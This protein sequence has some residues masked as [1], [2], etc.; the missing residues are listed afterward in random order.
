VSF[1]EWPSRAW[2]TAGSA[3]WMGAVCIRRLHAH[4]A[5]PII[6]ML[7][8]QGGQIAPRSLA[9]LRETRALLARE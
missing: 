7:T 9:S 2:R 8:Y 5:T 1:D 6:N 4:G 3:A